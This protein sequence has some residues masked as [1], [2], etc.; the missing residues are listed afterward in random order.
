MCFSS[1]LFSSSTVA[2]LKMAVKLFAFQLI[3]CGLT[4]ESGQNFKMM[5][6]EIGINYDSQCYKKGFVHLLAGIFG[7]QLKF[8]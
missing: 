5:G 1:P 4:F 2:I 8:I 6:G 3:L 7:F